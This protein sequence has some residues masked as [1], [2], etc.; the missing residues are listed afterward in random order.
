ML[1]SIYNY[2]IMDGYGIF[3]WVAFGLSFVILVGLFV[4]S[5]RLFRSSEKALEDLQIQV[6]QDE[7]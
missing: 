3:I 5:I 4:Q 2:F 6:T 1:E 7:K